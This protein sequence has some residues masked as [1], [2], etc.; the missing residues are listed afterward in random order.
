MDFIYPVAVDGLFRVDFAGYTCGRFLASPKIIFINIILMLYTR[1]VLC[2]TVTM[3][4]IKI[5]GMVEPALFDCLICGRPQRAVITCQNNFRS[6][7]RVCCSCAEVLSTALI[8]YKDMLFQRAL[9]FDE[10]AECKASE[11][12]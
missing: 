12:S 10:D 6:E 5:L 11:A 7:F 1:R 2:Y 3:E 8:D 9:E 4:S